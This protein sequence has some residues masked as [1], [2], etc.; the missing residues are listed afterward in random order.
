MRSLR[1]ALDLIELVFLCLSL[2]SLAK[3]T[4]SKTWCPSLIY[5]AMKNTLTKNNIG[6][7]KG[8]LDLQFQVHHFINVNSEIQTALYSQLRAKRE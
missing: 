2:L 8:L 4:V 5:I 3:N 6:V 1:V 7:E